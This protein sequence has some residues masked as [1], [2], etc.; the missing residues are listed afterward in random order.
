MSFKCVCVQP[1]D[2]VLMSRLRIPLWRQKL[3]ADISMIFLQKFPQILDPSSA[4]VA[5]SEKFCIESCWVSLGWLRLQWL[6]SYSL[7]LVSSRLS[8]DSPTK[9]FERLGKGILEFWDLASPWSFFPWWSSFL[10]MIVLHRRL[11]CHKICRL[12]IGCP[13]IILSSPPYVIDHED[14]ENDVTF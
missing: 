4:F 6:W 7:M 9:Y 5:L 14:D 10:F 8:N 11:T 12:D 3:Q 13:C 1:V 2:F